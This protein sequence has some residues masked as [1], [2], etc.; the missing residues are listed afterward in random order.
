MDGSESAS[1][2]SSAGAS[3]ERLREMVERGRVR[4]SLDQLL[5]MFGQRDTPE[6]REAVQDELEGVGLLTSPLLPSARRPR[7]KIDVYD[8]SEAASDHLLRN[9][10]FWAIL[11]PVVG[12]VLAL[13]LFAKERVGQGLVVLIVCLLTVGAYLWV[14]GSLDKPLYSVGLNFHECARNGL[15][16]TFCGHELTD[17]RERLRG[18][19]EKLE[20]AEHKSEEA[21]TKIKRESEEDQAK[22]KRESEEEQRRAWLAAEGRGEKGHECQP[23][24]QC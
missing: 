4:L 24:C 15:G 19:H 14:S 16:Q 23:Q 3:A 17:E 20:E 12:F 11:L 10:I 7:S 6:G 1:P 22:L 5:A 2:V 18:I 13:R 9:G 21:Q 8:A